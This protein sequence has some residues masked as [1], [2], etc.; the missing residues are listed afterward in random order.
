MSAKESAGYQLKAARKT[1]QQYSSWDEM[2]SAYLAG[3]RAWGGSSPDY[4]LRAIFT[5]DVAED[6]PFCQL[7][8]DLALPEAIAQ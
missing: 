4:Q 6:G 2:Y 5:A 3:M 1:Q 8:W 7:P